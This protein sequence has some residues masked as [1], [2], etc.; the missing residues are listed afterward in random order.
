MLPA[1]S[2]RPPGTW[3]ACLPKFSVP[4]G[5]SKHHRGGRKSGSISFG[6]PGSVLLSRKPGAEQGDFLGVGE[7]GVTLQARLQHCPGP[8]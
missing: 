8:S 7:P 5:A 6:N 2:G 1:G 4:W 3:G